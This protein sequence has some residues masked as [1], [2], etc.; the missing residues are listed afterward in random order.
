MPD[1]SFNIDESDAGSHSLIAVR[2]EI[3]RATAPQLSA[4]LRQATLE[5]E[6]PVVLDLCEVTY[7]DSA[8]ISVLLNAL[9]RLTRLRRRLVIAC[10]PGG[11]RRVFEITRLDDALAVMD[12]REEAIAGAA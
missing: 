3:D 9:R 11:V 8:G 12:S 2:G 5:R 7:I 1:Q 6:G 4:A 10:P